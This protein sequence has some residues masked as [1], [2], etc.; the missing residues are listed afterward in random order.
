M[1]NSKLGMTGQNSTWLAENV[2]VRS[3][4]Q[5]DEKT[6]LQAREYIVKELAVNQKGEGIRPDMSFH[7]HGAQQQ[8]G[9][10]GLAFASSQSFWARIF[11]G[12]EYALTKGQLDIVHDYLTEGLQWTCWKGFMDIGSCGRQVFLEAQ[13]GKAQTYGSALKNM[14]AADPAR[15]NEYQR[16]YDRDVVAVTDENTLTGNRFFQYSDYG[17]HRSAHWAA[18]LKMSSNR[19]IGSEIV[20]TENLLG[21]YMGDGALF[22]YR[23]GS[24][25]ENIFPVWDW[26]MLPGTTSYKTDSLFPGII[27][28][29]TY[30]NKHDFVGGVSGKQAGIAA[31]IVN[32]QELAARKS[33]FFTDIAIVC[34]GSDIRGAKN[35]EV[36][37]S[38]EQKL[39]KG[40]ILIADKGAG[41]AVYHDGMAYYS[42]G[43]RSLN[44]ESGKVEGNWQRVAAFAYGPTPVEKEVFKLWVSHGVSPEKASYA[45]MVFPD[46][47]ENNWQQQIDQSGVEPLQYNEK[48]HAI[49]YKNILQAVFFEPAALQLPDGQTLASEHPCILM[50]EQKGKEWA[51]SVCEPTQ[52]EKEIRLRLS[53]KWEG[54][55]CRYNEAAKETLI[56]LPTDQWTGKTMQYR[57]TQ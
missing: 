9:N 15:A 38:M 4:L 45:Y 23:E 18:G 28:S 43:S 51:Y 3:I 25:Y 11:G 7:Q 17:L 22:H 57:I 35:F 54:E 32:D 37:T 55:Y 56:T 46:V 34:M 6:F 52:K 30:N 16:I 50:M 13:R 24:E 12:T 29:K 31:M 19:T 2:L 33:Y 42:F 26:A 21:M 1:Q 47:T 53:G 40:N 5:K 14:M 39:K 8:F 49:R 10:Y 36:V 27:T 41:Q 20:N 48:L 44:V